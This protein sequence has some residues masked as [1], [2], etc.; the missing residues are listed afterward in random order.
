[1]EGLQNVANDANLHACTACKH[2]R[3]R[4]DSDVC[5][6]ALYFPANKS[7]EFQNVHRIYGVNNL[8]RILHSVPEHLRHKAVETL[9]LEATMR[10]EFPVSGSLA[11]QVQTRALIH[12]YEKELVFVKK[13][14]AFFKEMK[15]VIPHTYNHIYGSCLQ[16][17]P[18][19]VE[20]TRDAN[21]V[22]DAIST[23][24][25]NHEPSGEDSGEFECSDT[26]RLDE[27]IDSYHH[28]F[29][30]FG[31]LAEPRF[32]HRSIYFRDRISGQT[33]PRLVGRS[34]LKKEGIKAWARGGLETDTPMEFKFEGA[35]K[36]NT[37][38]SP[39]HQGALWDSP[40]IRCALA[41]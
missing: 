31:V 33:Y 9:I 24:E 15:R 25:N 21:L 36:T 19:T 23:G 22:S 8:I 4:C 40:S 2:Q 41:L 30:N 20:S 3:K 28:A 29:T 7:E 27:L 13:Q 26:Q 18:A 6:L 1:M 37:V 5:P 35:P 11:V 14:I 32:E 39:P 17:P 10:K 16:P 38:M 12:E 34:L